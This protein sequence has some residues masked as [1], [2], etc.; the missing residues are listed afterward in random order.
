MGKYFTSEYKKILDVLSSSGSNLSGSATSL[1]DS[2]QMIAANLNDSVSSFLSNPNWNGAAKQSFTGLL[3]DVKSVLSIASRLIANTLVKAAQLSVPG[4]RDDLKTIKEKDELLTTMQLELEGLKRA[5][6][7]AQI[8]YNNSNGASKETLNQATEKVNTQITAITKLE[9]ELNTLTTSINSTITSIKALNEA[10]VP[11]ITTQSNGNA[12]PYTQR[13]FDNSYMLNGTE[14][15]VVNINGFN[16]SLGEFA[17]T[18]ARLGVT[19]KGPGNGMQCLNFSMAYGGLILNDPGIIFNP[20][21]AYKQLRD[22]K[23]NSRPFKHVAANSKQEAL[24]IIQR[25]L[26]NGIPVVIKIYTNNSRSETHYGLAVGYNKA[27]K[28]RKLTEKDILFIDSYDGNI[29]QLGTNR[30]LT[31]WKSAI[32]S[33]T[34]GYSFKHGDER[35]TY[36]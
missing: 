21:E 9:R 6:E 10:A 19:N 20:S 24:D 33:Y 12:L 18:M 5:Q 22:R 28:G 8:A 15:Q 14:Y 11:K 23:W 25:D 17:N 30:H 31:G 4:L 26:D 32:F 3:N 2:H 13:G 29:E 27:A 35:N 34:P 16:N 36:A 1:S 7:G